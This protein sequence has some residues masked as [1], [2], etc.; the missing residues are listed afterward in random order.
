MASTASNSGTGTRRT[1][2]GGNGDQQYDQE[3]LDV[4][5]VV[6]VVKG[7][8]R[9][10]FRASVVVG[11]RAGTVGFGL[12]RSKDVQTAIQK[13]YNQA[14]KEVIHVD[15]SSG[16][17][18]HDVKAKFKG[19]VIILRPTRVGTGVIAGGPVRL[20]AQ[21]VGIKDIVSKRLGS[22]NKVSN[23]RATMVALS[24][25]PAKPSV[26]VRPA[27]EQQ[28]SEPSNTALQSGGQAGKPSDTAS[29]PSDTASKPSDTAGKPS[30]TAGKPS[31][32]KA[33]AKK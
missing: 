17:I 23:V 22:T 27:G 4:A 7:G 15:V 28:A 33:D 32:A 29:K 5:R 24:K 26:P 10:S 18:K 1:F 8:R 14:V 19:A 12:G 30:N 13:A 25:L 11:D 2:S 16:T 6:R 20:V 9:F 21:M 3:V 31:K